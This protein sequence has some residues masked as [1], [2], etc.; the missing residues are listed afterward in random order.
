MNFIKGDIITGQGYGKDKL[1]AFHPIIYIEGDTASD[2][3]GVMLTS[4]ASDTWNNNFP[5]E[6]DHFHT[7]DS[8]SIPYKI[9]FRKSSCVHL[10]LVKKSEW[11]PFLK[12]GQLTKKGVEYIEEKIKDLKPIS[13]DDYM[14]TINRT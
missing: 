11:A 12:K 4:S 5:L 3:I 14:A 8:E 6:E 1:K 13:W 2:F 9:V 7:H 10:R